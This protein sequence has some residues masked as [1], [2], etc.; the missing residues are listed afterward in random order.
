MAVQKKRQPG[1]RLHSS[2]LVSESGAHLGE[3]AD[4]TLAAGTGCGSRG[5]GV[6]GGGLG[7]VYSITQE[8]D[9]GRRR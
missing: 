9:S 2:S 5:G 8:S 7:G 3:H 1:R 6:V 4:S